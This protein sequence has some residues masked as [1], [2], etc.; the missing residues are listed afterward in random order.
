MRKW[1]TTLT[2]EPFVDKTR[3]DPESKS[4]D[5]TYVR[6]VTQHIGTNRENR[7]VMVAQSRKISQ[8]HRDEIIELKR[9]ATR[10]SRKLK[11]K[12]R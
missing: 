2:V 3:T 6:T 12:N 5:P 7:K 9:I 4:Y 1:R 10:R 8:A 11:A